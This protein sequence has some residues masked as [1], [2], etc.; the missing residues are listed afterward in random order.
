M[1]Y[2]GKTAQEI[3]DEILGQMPAGKRLELTYG[4]SR[5]LMELNKLGDPN[6]HRVSDAIKKN[7]SNSRK[8]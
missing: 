2:K 3:Q 7:R 5:F 6:D 1:N 4:L 8:T